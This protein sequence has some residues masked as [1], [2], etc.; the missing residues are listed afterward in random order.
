M[1]RFCLYFYLI[2]S[3]KIL[4]DIF[5]FTFRRSRIWSPNI[6]VCNIK[7]I[8]LLSHLLWPP[9]KSEYLCFTLLCKFWSVFVFFIINSCDFF[10]KKKSERPRY[11]PT[12]Q[13][14]APRITISGLMSFFV[15]LCMFCGSH[16]QLR[17][18]NDN[19]QTPT[20]KCYLFLKNV[21]IFLCLINKKIY[22]YL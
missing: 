20:G 5:H 17:A 13:T 6:L 8:Y 16:F 19:L 4:S 10:S 2:S 14:V 7:V 11:H 21:F 12:T 22:T 1:F 3:D 18:I 15:Y 9:T